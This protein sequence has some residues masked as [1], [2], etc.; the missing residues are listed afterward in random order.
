MGASTAYGTGGLWTHLQRD[1]AV[2]DNDETIAAYLEVALAERL[3]RR[4]EVIN[5]AIPAV[6]THHHLIY[7]YQ[8][9]LNFDPD[10][11]LFLDGFNDFYF[12]SEGHDQF[13]SFLYKE[14]SHV[15]MGPPTLRALFVANGWWL[16]RK[17]ALIHAVGRAGQYLGRLLQPT[18]ERHPIDVGQSL[19]EDQDGQDGQQGDLPR[20]E[21]AE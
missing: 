2:L 11:V 7:L 9:I 4:V 20:A 19:A 16:F 13:A 14:H 15:I 12:A 17:S 1:F 3:D 8:T 6:W 21:R 5:A 18:P 10:M